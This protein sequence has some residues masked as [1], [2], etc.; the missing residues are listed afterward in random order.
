MVARK[1]WLRLLSLGGKGNDKGS[2]IYFHS[3]E[4]A[5][6]EKNNPFEFLNLLKESLKVRPDYDVSIYRYSQAHT[7]NPLRYERKEAKYQDGYIE[8]TVKHSIELIE[9]I[10]NNED[11]VMK[12]TYKLIS[13]L[14]YFSKKNSKITANLNNILDNLSE[15]S[16][17]VKKVDTPIPKRPC[18]LERINNFI[19]KVDFTKKDMD[20][21]RKAKILSKDHLNS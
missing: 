21:L 8:A 9:N 4:L 19:Q 3:L 16:N 13:D 20:F 5:L 14:V 2:H 18:T 11:E 12:E 7:N 1:C 17:R 15:F 6:K 10:T